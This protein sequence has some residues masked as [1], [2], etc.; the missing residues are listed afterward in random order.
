MNQTS[1]AQAIHELDPR[2]EILVVDDQEIARLRLRDEL[3]KHGFRVRVAESGERALEEIHSHVPDLVILDVRMGEGHLDGT[4]VCRALRRSPHTRAIPVI[5]LTSVDGM[6]AKIEAL[7]CGANDYVTKKEGLAELEELVERAKNHLDFRDMHRDASPLTRLP[8][9]T[10]IERELRQRIEAGA[11][12]AYLYIDIDWFKAFNDL[13]G[14]QRGDEIIF[15]T[16]ELLKECLAEH[17]NDVDFIGHVGGDDFVVMCASERAQAIAGSIGRK[18]DSMILDYL[19]P[20]DRERGYLEVAGRTGRVER[21]SWSVTT[22]GVVVGGQGQTF[23]HPGEVSARAA[24]VKRNAK[25]RHWRADNKPGSQVVW[26]RR[27]SG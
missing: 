18:F 5:M 22:A 8:G 16:A 10:Q 11:P 7:R 23:K 13:Y 9:N 19:D 21:H 25:A 4:Q 2:R 1:R 24:E 14:H 17:G 15:A 20:R 12:F 3:E 27:A 6:E 26:E